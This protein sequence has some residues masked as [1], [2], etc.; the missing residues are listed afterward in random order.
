MLPAVPVDSVRLM[1][2]TLRAPTSPV[3]SGAF[4]MRCASRKFVF[5]IDAACVVRL[6]VPAEFVYEHVKVV[7]VVPMRV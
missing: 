6:L 4:R 7:P 3:A 2:C 5:P 1:F